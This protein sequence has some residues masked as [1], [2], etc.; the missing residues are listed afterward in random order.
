[1]HGTS[2]A[3]RVPSK[4]KSVSNLHR[5]H[6]A[7][8]GVLATV[9]VHELRK[10]ANVQMRRRAH[11]AQN[12]VLTAL[13]YGLRC[14]RDLHAYWQGQLKTVHRVVMFG[15]EYRRAMQVDELTYR[16]L[17]GQIELTETVSL[18][19]ALGFGWHIGNGPKQPECLRRKMQAS[20][21]VAIKVRRESF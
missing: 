1:M 21:A 2:A 18:P 16:E 3:L 6:E 8:L 7:L 9:R 17:H 5:F 4:A 11:D 14:S 19:V 10:D 15:V 20:D 12:V 13:M